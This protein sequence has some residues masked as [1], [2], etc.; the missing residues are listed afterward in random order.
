MGRTALHQP[1]YASCIAKS[2]AQNR[3]ITEATIT[4]ISNVGTSFMIR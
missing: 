3:T 2:I 4:T 1:R